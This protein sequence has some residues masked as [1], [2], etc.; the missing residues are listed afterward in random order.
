MAKFSI[1]NFIDFSQ[2]KDFTLHSKVKYNI[3]MNKKLDLSALSP[4]EQEKIR[5]LIEENKQLKAKVKTLDEAAIK[6]QSEN[7]QQ[8]EEIKTINDTV[9]E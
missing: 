6:F 5:L 9:T 3:Y 2:L 7:I 4:E 1:V 8:D